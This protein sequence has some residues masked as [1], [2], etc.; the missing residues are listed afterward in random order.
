MN[1]KENISIAIYSIRTHLMR[2]LLTMLGVI[3]GVFSV[4]AVITI[5]NGGR[6]YIVG[7]VRD[8][9]QN[10]V[11]V[12]VDITKVDASQYITRVDIAK[13]K[14]LENVEY[15]SPQNIVIGSADTAAKN[16]LAVM[17]SGTPD[18]RYTSSVEV[19]NGR[20]FNEDDYRGAARVCLI[21]KISAEGLFGRTNVV[22]EYIDFSANGQTMRLRIV[23][24]CDINLMGGGEGGGVS[25]IASGLGYGTTGEFTI[26]VAPMTLTDMM[27]NS[28]GAYETLQVVA[29][30]DKELDAVGNAAVNILYTNHGNRS[31]GKIYSYTKVA[32]F[33]DILDKVI[34]I[35]T[36]FIAGVSAISLLV[37][38]IGVMNIMLVSVT[39]RTREIGIRKALGAKTSTIMFQFLTESIILCM[40]GGFIGMMLGVVSAQSVGLLMKVPIAV[41]FSTLAIAI[42][43][44]TAIGVFFGIYPARRAAKMLPIDA[45]RR[46]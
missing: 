34:N 14:Q 16:S 42:G 22:G 37:G 39:E 24:V 15:V 30:D 45:L 11:N 40:I 43:F 25:D 32:T 26:M 44:S 2:S 5:G 7:M 10:L 18:L 36:T 6:D 23:G 46:D 1:F 13:I 33:I 41:E 12:K 4:I 38:G 17:F 29:T 35:L 27:N 9:G 21:A 8:M 20:F 28:N 3:I 19:L 31:S